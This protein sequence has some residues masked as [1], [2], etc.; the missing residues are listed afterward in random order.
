MRKDTEQI[1]EL[2]SELQRLSPYGPAGS[3]DEPVELSEILDGR[4]PWT[5]V[6]SGKVLLD[7]LPYMA[8]VHARA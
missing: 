2:M 5:P 8:S 4:F 3:I 6:L 1:R 7:H